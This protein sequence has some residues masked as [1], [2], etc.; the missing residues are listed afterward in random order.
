MRADLFSGHLREVF[1]LIEFS[2]KPLVIF[3][4]EIL[5]TVGREG[6]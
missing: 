6:L 4:S 1:C 3:T 5:K 2:P